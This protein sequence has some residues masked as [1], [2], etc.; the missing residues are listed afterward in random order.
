MTVIRENDHPLK[1]NDYRLPEKPLLNKLHVLLKE[2]Q[3]KVRPKSLLGE[4][5]PYTLNQ[6]PKLLV[7]LDDGTL[8]ITIIVLSVDSK[9][10]QPDEKRSKKSTS[11]CI[12]FQSKSLKQS[13]WQSSYA[14][15]SY[16]EY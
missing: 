9:P 14:K 5:I 11:I 6:W 4:A 13:Y 3:R 1:P 15:K 12:S 7:Y 16:R 2:K 8:R 10:S